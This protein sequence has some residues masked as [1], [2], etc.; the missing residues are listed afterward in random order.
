MTPLHSVINACEDNDTTELYFV[1]Y[2]S[3]DDHQ[4]MALTMTMFQLNDSAVSSCGD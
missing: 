3:K 2:M 4:W 1:S